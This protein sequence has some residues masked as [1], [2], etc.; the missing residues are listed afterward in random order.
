MD[1]LYLFLFYASLLSFGFRS[2]KLQTIGAEVSLF[3]LLGTRCAISISS[4]FMLAQIFLKRSTQ[5][6]LVSY[7]DSFTSC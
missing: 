6:I 4:K 5:S 1:L 2:T 7:A 3:L